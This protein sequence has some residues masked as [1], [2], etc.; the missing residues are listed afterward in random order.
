MTAKDTNTETAP[1]KITRSNR[2]SRTVTA[3]PLPDGSIEVLAPSTISDAELGPIIERLVQRL[4]RRAQKR[5]LSDTDLETRCRELNKR[6]FNG[7]L[8]WK[9]IVWVTNQNHRFGSC[10]PSL[11][12]IR[13]SDRLAKA[14]TWVLDYVLVHEL[15]HLEQANHSPAFWKLVNRYPL[16]ERA[17]GYLMALGLEDEAAGNNHQAEDVE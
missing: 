11:G 1:I 10:T 13:I 4:G 12:T 9:S 3:R 2:R 14:P 16:T 15:A 6:H 5:Q 17:R 8:R 7:R